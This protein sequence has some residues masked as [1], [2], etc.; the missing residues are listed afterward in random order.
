M[1][2]L[3]GKLC[4]H[5]QVALSKKSPYVQTAHR[6]SGLMLAN[7]TSI[8]HLFNKIMR[9]YGQL[10][11]PRNERR[12]FLDPYGQFARFS[13]NGSLVL[14]EFLDAKEVVQSLSAEYEACERADYVTAAVE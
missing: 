6:V 11:G 8:R 5:A 14:D 2:L 9:D 13:D 3:E 7:N 10:M 1:C 12:A 4:A